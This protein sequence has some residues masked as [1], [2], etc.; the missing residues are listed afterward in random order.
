M[1]AP[2]LRKNEYPS[3]VVRGVRRGFCAESRVEAKARMAARKLRESEYP[4]C[5]AGECGE[6]FV[7]SRE[8]RQVLGWLRVS[9]ARASVPPDS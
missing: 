4:S 5:F 1:A 9:C 7:R 3:C 2:K 6:A 8:L